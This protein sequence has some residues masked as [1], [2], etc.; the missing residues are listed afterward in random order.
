MKGKGRQG[1]HVK[2]QRTKSN[3]DRIE[4]GRWVWVGPGE[5]VVK[6]WRQLY[7]NNKKKKEKTKKK[8]NSYN[9]I[10]GRQSNIYPKRTYRWP[11]DR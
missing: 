4:G 2:D 11:I 3:G 10:P 7:L 5:V 6:K 1:T 8:K 9:A